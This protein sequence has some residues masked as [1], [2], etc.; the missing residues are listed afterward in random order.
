M[1]LNFCF[2]K[3]ARSRLVGQ[4]RYGN[5]VFE[6]IIHMQIHSNTYIL[7]EEEKNIFKSEHKLFRQFIKKQLK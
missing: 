3:H 1:L 7:T 5:R 4:Y 6:N 2:L